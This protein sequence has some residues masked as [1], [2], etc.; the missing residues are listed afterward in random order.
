MEEDLS[1]KLRKSLFFIA[2][3]ECFKGGGEGIRELM[4]LW[5]WKSSM[6]QL[7]SSAWMI[8]IIF[9]YIK[10]VMIMNNIN[11]PS[12]KDKRNIASFSYISLSLN[13]Y[14]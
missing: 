12:F 2:C 10:I 5:S 9:C 7:Q 4:I 8:M 11:L 3:S 13:E 1:F 6:N 14:W